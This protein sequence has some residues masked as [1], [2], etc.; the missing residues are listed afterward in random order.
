MQC[1]DV[2]PRRA[3]P[4]R[5]RLQDRG[6]DAGRPVPPHPACRAGGKVQE[7]ASLTLSWRGIIYLALTSPRPTKAGFWIE[8]DRLIGV[9]A[10]AVGVA[11]GAISDTSI[12]E[13]RGEF[14]N[15]PDRLIIIGNGTVGVALVVVGD[16]SI[17]EGNGVFGIEPDRLI[18]VGK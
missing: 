17:V 9:G 8:P 13:G 14:G 1:R 11:L 16:S 2:C 4:D 10:R 6:R 7:I 3:N 15:E 18:E 5:W 12:A